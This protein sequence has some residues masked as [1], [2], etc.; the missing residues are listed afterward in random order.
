M[1]LTRAER[2]ALA[3]SAAI[4]LAL[5]VLLL[6]SGGSGDAPGEVPALVAPAD[7]AALVLPGRV[8]FGGTAEDATEP[9]VALPADAPQ[10]VGIVGRIGRDAV[11][12]VRS[13][14][15][16]RT[17]AP[18]ESVDGWRLESL[19]IDAAFFTRGAQRMRVPLPAG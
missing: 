3:A 5:P 9:E 16:S 11:A 14:G 1:A 17:L 10:L 18:G 6:G 8:L 13:G 7:P 12:L 19:A 2:A 4:M 15:V